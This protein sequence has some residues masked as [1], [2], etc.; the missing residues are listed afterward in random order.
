[1]N[2]KKSKSKKKKIYIVSS[3]R[4]TIKSKFK[5]STSF[6]AIRIELICLIN[7]CQQWIIVFSEA[8]EKWGNM[9]RLEIFITFISLG[10][11]NKKQM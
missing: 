8:K 4:R 1:M 11:K 7:S 5:V 3:D 2:Q 9:Y 6:L 10:K